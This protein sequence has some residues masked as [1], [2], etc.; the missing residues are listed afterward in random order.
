MNIDD[1]IQKQNLK[2]FIP[3]HKRTLS[4]TGVILV[5]P[6]LPQKFEG[7]KVP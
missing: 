4:V 2:I 3:M 1:E 7:E 5:L 6:S